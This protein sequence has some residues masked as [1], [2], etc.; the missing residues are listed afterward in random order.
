MLSPCFHDLL[1][2]QGW[3]WWHWDNNQILCQDAQSGPNIVS[4]FHMTLYLLRHSVYHPC[5]I[6][7]ELFISLWI[8]A[9]IATAYAAILRGWSWAVFS[10]DDISPLPTAIIL[11]GAPQVLIMTGDNGGQRMCKVVIVEG[12]RINQYNYRHPSASA[13]WNID[14]IAWTAAPSWPVHTCRGSAA[15]S[16]YFFFQLCAELPS[17]ITS[18]IP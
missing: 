11:T 3:F 5:F 8:S 13:S 7:G 17:L 15:S 16:S 10:V 18:P 9:T 4:G 1:L 14:R 12:I 2:Q 6:S